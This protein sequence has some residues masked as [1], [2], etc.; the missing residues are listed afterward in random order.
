MNLKVLASNGNYTH[1]FLDILI[2]VNIFIF[3][4]G[5]DQRNNSV[6]SDIE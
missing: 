3:L 5:I 2:G 1:G 6:R 4:S